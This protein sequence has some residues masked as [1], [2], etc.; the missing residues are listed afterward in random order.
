[1]EPCIPHSDGTEKMGCSMRF[2]ILRRPMFVILFLV[3]NLISILYFGFIASPLYS[4]TASL[5]VI[6][7]QQ[8]GTSMTSLLSGGSSDGSEQGAYILKNHIESWEAFKKVEQPLALSKNFALGDFVSRYGGLARLFRKDDVALWNYYKSSVDIDVDQKGSIVALTVNGYRPGFAVALARALLD[9][10]VRH[11]DQ[12][13]LQQEQDYVGSALA[14]RIELQK[15][16]QADETELA[17][18]RARIG[19]YDPK[20]L[21]LS[22]L[23]LL[24]SLALK[25]AD[26]KSQYDTVVKAMPNN[27]A[28]QNLISAMGAVRAQIAATKGG[29]S[30]LARNAAHYENLVVRRDST[31]ALL[32]Q[33]N[34][35]VQEAQSTA[36]KNKF[37][38]N[39]ISRPSEPQTPEL[40]RRAL[41]IGGI[42]LVTLVLWGLLR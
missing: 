23:S 15:S 32:N 8:A 4:S 6:N 37:Y 13:N 5:I 11:M 36:M 38:L 40:P 2:D 25:D 10:S 27:P 35:A 16:L 24:N 18:Y 1:M 7:P 14:R 20:E 9:E 31:I 22:N 39:V 12:M 41:W 34:L 29:F 30:G 28:A 42:L 3:P 26:L 17:E 21:Y 19:N 33:A